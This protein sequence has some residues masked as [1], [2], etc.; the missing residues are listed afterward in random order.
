M[1]TTDPSSKEGTEGHLARSREK[2]LGLERCQRVKLP[3]PE[4]LQSKSSARKLLPNNANSSIKE[5]APSEV[6]SSL[7][8]EASKT[9][10]AFWDSVCVPTG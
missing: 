2:K 5:W 1:L 6:V 9:L 8:L 3:P 7:A 4:A 10:C